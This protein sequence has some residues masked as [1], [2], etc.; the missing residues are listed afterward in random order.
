MSHN[1]YFADIIKFAIMLIRKAFKDS[2]KVKRIR[3]YA[4]KCFFYLLFL[5]VTK[6]ANFW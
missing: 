1:V 2:I 3:N 6:I 4:C 5:D